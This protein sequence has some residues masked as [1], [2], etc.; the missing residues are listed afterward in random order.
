M[1]FDDGPGE[2]KCNERAPLQAAREELDGH[3]SDNKEQVSEKSWE[4]S[5]D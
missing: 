5:K 1:L 2:A 4:S 3:T